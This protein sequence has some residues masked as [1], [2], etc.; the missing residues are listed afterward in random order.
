MAKDVVERR[1]AHEGYSELPSFGVEGNKEEML[2]MPHADDDMEN[3]EKKL[4][5]IEEC[6]KQPR[7]RVEG[8]NAALHCRQNA[9]STVMFAKGKRCAYG[10]CREV[11]IQKGIFEA[12]LTLKM[13]SMAAQKSWQQCQGNCTR[14]PV[15]PHFQLNSNV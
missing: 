4:C 12:G 15:F 1:C 11:P 2:C 7:F 3:V 8:D 10:G 9:D 5:Q 6:S 14:D 13:E